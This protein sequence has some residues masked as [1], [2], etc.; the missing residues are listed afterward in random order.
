MAVHAVGGGCY[1]FV[2]DSEF[3]RL[4][5]TARGGRGRGNTRPCRHG[6]VGELFVGALA[7]CN[8][9]EPPPLCATGG[10]K[11][12]AVLLVVAF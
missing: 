6:V 8:G 9:C 1:R 7:P 12:C 3:W 2:G 4:V 5:K 10:V 11:H